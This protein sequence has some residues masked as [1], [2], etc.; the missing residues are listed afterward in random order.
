MLLHGGRIARQVALANR[1]QFERETAHLVGRFQAE[2]HAS[3]RRERVGRVGGGVVIR[4]LHI[5]AR[6][7]LQPHG[8]REV[9]VL[10][11]V[12]IPAWNAHQRARRAAGR[13]RDKAHVGGK[14]VRVPAA[15][16]HI[17]VDRQR[18]GRVH[19]QLIP[20]PR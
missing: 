15:T 13:C 6:A 9:V 18:D 20:D 10:L 19:H 12:E 5:Q 16:E 3:R 17:H 2:H 4:D 8:L 1:Q 7:R 11:P 14:V